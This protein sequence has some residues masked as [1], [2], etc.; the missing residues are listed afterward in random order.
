V[1]LPRLASGTWVRPNRNALG[2]FAV[3]LG[4]WYA[5]ITQNN[6]AA[7]LLCF[8]LTAV[9]LISIIHAWSNLE[10]VVIDADPVRPVFAGEEL[11]VHLHASSPRSRPHYGIRVRAATAGNA[12]F[13]M[14]PEEGRVTTELRVLAPKRG[15]HTHLTLKIESRFPLGFFTAQRQVRL[16]LTHYVYPAPEGDRPLPVSPVRGRASRDGQKMEGD[17]FGGVRTWRVG[18]SQRHID[19][20]AAARGQPLLIKQWSGDGGSTTQL[21]WADLR[22]IRIE[23]R[24][25]QLSRWVVTAERNGI[26]YGL[27]LP[28]ISLPLSRGEA[29]YHACLRRL[30]E[31]RPTVPPGPPAEEATA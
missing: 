30:A 8:V 4:M 3:L 18:E 9:G 27:R 12:T 20:K 21:D 13:P 24:L 25:S 5:G 23:D 15:L 28:Q 22:G 7:Y 10:G 1:K 11:I 19:W 26:Q 31:Y 29:H 16:A 14:L 2:L 17:D 6:G